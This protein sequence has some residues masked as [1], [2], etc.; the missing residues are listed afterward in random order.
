[1]QGEPDKCLAAGLDDFAAKPT[2]I[3]T[4]A[5]RLARWLPHLTWTSEEP[6]RAEPHAPTSR[7]RA[8]WTDGLVD[9]VALDALTGGDFELAASLVQDFLEV[10]RADLHA[11]CAALDARDTDDAHRQAHRIKGAART[12]GAHE[13]ARLAE[14]IEAAT[15]TRRDDTPDDWEALDQLAAQ[16]TRDPGHVRVPA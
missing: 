1:M 13:I 11:L 3:P 14:Q 9:E 5:G 16:I 7:S 6:E 10:T 2:T 12:V 4:L 8:P 15:A